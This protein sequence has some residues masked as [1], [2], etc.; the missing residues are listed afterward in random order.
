MRRE[1]LRILIIAEDPDDFALIR[2]LLVHSRPNAAHHIDGCYSVPDAEHHLAKTPYDLLLISEI[3][4]GTSGAEVLATLRKT[5]KVPPAVLLAEHWNERTM[6]QA[7]SAGA[8][9]YLHKRTLSFAKLCSAI[10]AGVCLPY[11]ESRNREAEDQLRKLSRAV[12][13]S[14]DLVIITDR[15]GVI[16]MLIRLFRRSPATPARKCSVASPTC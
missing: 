2:D 5:H 1:A 10:R 13:Q 14:G 4:R 6:R 7:F 11:K 8:T 9:D 15:T 3:V 12:E 16:E